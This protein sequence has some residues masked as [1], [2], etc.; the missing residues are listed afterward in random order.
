M[1]G[2]SALSA[3]YLHIMRGSI[4]FLQILDTAEKFGGVIGFASC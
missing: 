4:D 3:Y 1:S 2:R